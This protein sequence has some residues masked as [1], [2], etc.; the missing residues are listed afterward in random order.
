MYRAYQ[1]EVGVKEY[2]SFCLCFVGVNMRW[3]LFFLIDW[4]AMKFVIF[5]ERRLFK[6]NKLFNAQ[7][8][9]A[10]R[11]LSSFPNRY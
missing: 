10:F 5:M 8:Y 4:F 9:K 6:I 2:L 7:W 1:K 3:G 11:S